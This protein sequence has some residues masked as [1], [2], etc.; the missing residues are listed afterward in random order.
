MVKKLLL[1]LLLVTAMVSS[2]SAEMYFWSRHLSVAG[3]T[4]GHSDYSDARFHD[5]GIEITNSNITPTA[6]DTMLTGTLT[7]SGGSYSF[8]DN[9]K[10]QQVSGTQHTFNLAF[11]PDGVVG[12]GFLDYPPVNSA[13]NFLRFMSAADGGL[14]GVTGNAVFPD[15]PDYNVQG[16]I[17]NFRTT[18][19]Q[20]STFVPYVEYIRSGSQ[21]T[22][23]TWRVVNPADTSKAVS[24]DFEMRF[25]V[26]AVYGDEYEHLYN[27]S[28]MTIPAGELP[29]GIISFGEPIDESEI[30][31]IRI[32]LRTYET[33]SSSDYDWV[34][35][36]AI[37][38][39]PY[40]WSNH[41]SQASLINGKSSYEDAEFYGIH[42]DVE[43]ENTLIEAKHLTDS[44]RIT[45]SG[46]GYIVREDEPDEF[47]SIR[48][49]ASGQDTSFVL[50][51]NKNIAVDIG[52]DSTAHYYPFDSGKRLVLA[53]GAE[54]GLN[55]KAVSWTFP[56]SSELNGS[57][58]MPNFKSVNEQLAQGVP[59]IELVSADGKITAINY[60]IVTAAN[61]QTAIVPSYSTDFR[62]FIDYEDGST[63]RSDWQR[64]TAYGRSILDEAVPLENLE[65]IR[66]R[67][68]SREDSANPAVYQWNFYTTS[69][70]QQTSSGSSSSSGC[71][72]G[73]TLTALFLTASLFLKK[74]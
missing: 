17:P 30:W 55:G 61:T 69:A 58:V 6:E 36:N 22:G 9:G 48:T 41:L 21:V 7:L 62:F 71:S 8:W 28:N 38:E 16:S 70:S 49:V 3:L 54:K 15:N 53:G 20:L 72:T 74:R 33:G 12:S 27:G 2:A 50:E 42:I 35:F 25:R 1:C 32:R 60:R 52:G 14:N 63:Y 68:R 44:G 39:E 64:N 29:E 47:R 46:G 67:F 57:A 37:N 56:D 4:D 19:E 65:R 5:V 45:I 51:M 23:L 31:A 18:Q 10:L 11:A 59:Y 66:V 26:R 13:G 43:R 40:L 24:Q 73:F 34:F